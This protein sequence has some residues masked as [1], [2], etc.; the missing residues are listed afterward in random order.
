MIVLKHDDV[1]KKSRNLDYYY[2]FGFFCHTRIYLRDMEKNNIKQCQIQKGKRLSLDVVNLALYD[3]LETRSIGA[4]EYIELKQ[5]QFSQ[6]GREDCV[7]CP[8]MKKNNNG[9]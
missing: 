5:N 3:S 7:K 6:R 4:F 2:Y 9:Y 8:Y 1:I